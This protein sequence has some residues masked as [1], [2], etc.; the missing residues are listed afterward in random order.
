VCRTLGNNS[1]IILAI[2]I[3]GLQHLTSH[4]SG[5]SLIE[6]TRTGVGIGAAF[7]TTRINGLHLVCMRP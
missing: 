3:F 7:T 2:Y 4:D 6:S 5:G 1:S